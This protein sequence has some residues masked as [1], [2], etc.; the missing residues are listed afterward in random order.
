M[1]Q[2]RG[3]LK[4]GEGPGGAG[5]RDPPPPSPKPCRGRSTAR[6]RGAAALCAH[7]SGPPPRVLAP[8]P[9]FPRQ[10]SEGKLKAVKTL[11]SRG[12]RTLGPGAQRF[13]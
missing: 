2:E 7:P 3:R 9:L 6:S 8:P 13:L 11:V 12:T 4:G 10:P 5:G 1:S